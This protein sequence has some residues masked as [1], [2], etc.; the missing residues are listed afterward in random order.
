MK[1]LTFNGI[2]AAFLA[3]F[4]LFS[5]SSDDNTQEP[6]P[7]VNPD[8]LPKDELWVIFNGTEKWA[9][10]IYA[11][12]DA[13]SR[14]MDL[15]AIPFY[16][17]GYSAGGRVVDNVLYKKDGAL[18]SEVGLSKYKMEGNKFAADGFISTPNNTYETN[19]LVVNATEGY[20]W[21]S[22]AG[23]L[24]VQKFNPQTMQRIGEVDFSSLS[25]GSSYEAAGQLILAKRENKLYVDIQHGTRSTAWQVKPNVEKVE[26]AV[27]DLTTNKIEG[28]TSYEGATNLGLFADHVLWSL[29]EVTQ[30]L[31][32]IAVGDMTVQKPESKILR[33]KRGEIK[34][35]PTFELKISDYQYPSDF[36]RIFA[37]NNKVYTTIS[38]RPTSYYGGGQHGVSYRKDIWYWNEIDVHTKKA[39]RLEM[40]PDNFYSYQNPF[41]HNG[42]IYFIS[43][44]SEENFAG[45]YQ[46]NP[47]TGEVKETFRLKGSGR[48]MGFHIMDKNK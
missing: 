21:D 14:V 46:Y 6:T 40:L 47:K 29:D 8:E 36:N 17:L 28:V 5:C 12:G 39:T 20:Y 3:T 35:D 26:I 10:G 4:L 1:K 41:Y 13:K 24:K 30:D 2:A 19:Y 38:S 31:Y 33:I 43:N 18:A 7:P 44:N 37:H 11:L 23:G 22:A 15:S 42:N 27:Y 45:A 32:V 9:G 34:F 25:D 48:L 16:Q